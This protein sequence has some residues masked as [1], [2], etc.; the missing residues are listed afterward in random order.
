MRFVKNVSVGHALQAFVAE[1]D[2]VIAILSQPVHDPLIDVHVRQKTHQVSRSLNLFLGKPSGV[3][4][5]LLDIFSVQIGISIKYF[6]ESCTVCNLTDNHRNGN[7]H[8]TDTCS[9]AH[10]I[11]MECD[12]V[13]HGT[14]RG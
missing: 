1:M 13:E 7:P 8:A 3:L 10:D 12:S 4:D 2:G 9:A 11:G 6:L 14:S 5:C